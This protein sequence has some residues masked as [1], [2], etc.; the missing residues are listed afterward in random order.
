MSK[1]TSWLTVLKQGRVL[2]KYPP[3]LRKFAL[4]ISFFST[5]AYEQLRKHLLA[6]VELPHVKT[7]SKWFQNVN[8]LPGITKQSLEYLKNRINEEKIKNKKDLLFALMMDE[9]SIRAIERW[10][11]STKEQQGYV[12]FGDLCFEDRSSDEI[13]TNAL[14][15]ILNGINCRFKI[16]VAFF[17][18][19]NLNAHERKNVATLI[20][21]TLYEETNAKIVTFTFDGLR[22]NLKMSELMGA[23]MSN[24]YSS[25][26]KIDD[27]PDGV[28]IS[29]DNCHMLK[30][31]RNNLGHQQ[32]FYYKERKIEWR[33]FQMLEEFQRKKGLALAPRLTLQHIYFENQKMKVRLATQLFS[34]SVSKALIYLQNR[35]SAFKYCLPTAK[36]AA[37]FNDLFDIFNSSSQ[38][39]TYIYKCGASENN[40][41][42][43]F[44]K[45]DEGEEYIKNLFYFDY[46]SGTKIQ[47]LDNRCL[48]N[49]GFKGFLINIDTFRNLIKSY[50]LPRQL[51]YLLFYKISQDHLELFFGLIRQRGGHN[52]N[53]DCRQFIAAYKRLVVNKVI[54]DIE[55]IKTGNCVME[56]T[57]G[58]L[59]TSSNAAHHKEINPD[60][61]LL[62]MSL[63]NDMQFE[64]SNDMEII[65]DQ[66]K[67]DI[68]CYIAG[69]IM[70]KQIDRFLTCDDCL[71]IIHNLDKD[72]KN[73]RLIE[74][75]KFGNLYTPPKDITMICSAAEKS[76]TMYGDEKKKVNY[77]FLTIKSFEF[78][79]YNNIFLEMKD[80]LNDRFFGDHKYQSIKLIIELYLKIRLYFI[81][82]TKNNN[83]IMLRKKFKKLTHF[84]ESK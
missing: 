75:K 5:A 34:L 58:I 82:K 49:T 52:D 1:D 67:M 44:K 35:E 25:K 74:L 79:N 62:K 23:D 32:T 56:D 51:N 83:K 45:L 80:H 2:G 40:I 81:A 28:H 16:P 26:I 42:K 9:M 41:S 76:I 65:P 20:I 10:D 48:F 39:S 46:K 33:Y 78:I 68:V 31:V 8:G 18:I 12:D 14:V 73:N 6:E 64:C 36:F 50:V 61:E 13:A 43:I 24:S 54:K 38:Y 29:L 69:F 53:P 77:L 22:A 11:D 63:D 55:N 70:N 17:F 3:E 60:L 84:Y 37:I 15:F 21:K 19:T 71:E 27:V 30:L 72:L 66:Y 47:I 4:T 7:I 57:T 59:C